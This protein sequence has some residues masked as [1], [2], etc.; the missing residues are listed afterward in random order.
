MKKSYLRAGQAFRP[1]TTFVKLK[2][3]LKKITADRKPKM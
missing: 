1:Q 2:D 3:V